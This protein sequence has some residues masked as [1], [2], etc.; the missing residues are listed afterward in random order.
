M[1]FMS[2]SLARVDKVSPSKRPFM[3]GFT[4]IEVLIVVVLLGILATIALPQ[5]RS[6]VTKAHAANILG[7]VRAVQLAY[8]HFIADDGGRTRNSG[9]GRVPLD[10][11]EY[12]P[13]GFNFRTDIADYRWV[14]LRPRAS[15][16]GVESAELRVRP[17]SRFRPELVDA[18]ADM[19]SRTMIVKKR[20]HIRFYMVP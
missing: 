4:L 18:L 3:L 10:L 9:W 7:D 2:F 12:L 15:P 16:F 8:S 5:Y 20:N 6:V 13:D 14:R 19:A 17:Q 1:L 11:E